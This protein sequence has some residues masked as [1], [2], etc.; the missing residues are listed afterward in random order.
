M[1][2][3]HFSK[4]TYGFSETEFAKAKS[5]SLTQFVDE[6]LSPNSGDDTICNEKLAA[7]Q[8]NIEYEHKVGNRTKKVKEDRP[9][10]YLS[11]SMTELWRLND[12]KVH[13]EEKQRP[14]H[15]VRMASWIRAVYSRWQVHELMVEFWHNHFNVSTD[16][17][18]RIAITFPVYDRD[19]IRK[20]TFGNF[21]TLLEAVSQS[22]AMLI[23]LDNYVSKASPAN[24]NYARELFELHTLGADHYL[25]HLYNRWREVPG[26]IEG[27]PVGYIDEDVYEAARAFTGWTIADGSDDERGGNFPNTGNFHYYEGWHDNYQK[28]ILGYEL[29]PNQAPLND[30]RKVL[31]LVAFHPGTAKHICSKLCRRFI[32]DDPPASI[33]DKAVRTWTEHQKSPDQ[34]RRTLRTIFLSEEFNNASNQKL[35]RPF[36]L[37]VSVLRASATDFNPNTNLNWILAR[38]GYKHFTWPTPTGHPDVESYWANSNMMLGRWNMVPTLLLEDWHNLT[39]WDDAALSAT[40]KLSCVQLAEFWLTKMLP[41][42][43]ME[44]LRKRTVNLLAMGGEETDPPAGSKEE[45]IDRIKKTVC[46][47]AMSPQFQYR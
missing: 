6:Q 30:G 23:Y 34:I 22:S 45:V 40:M 1:N 14:A 19:V 42:S 17:N 32:S 21:R 29:P 47:I 24:E 39:Q 37:A 41:E 2:P 10:N 18:E 8:L 3:S 43:A 33:I 46:L 15:E 25:N 4:L 11:A 13:Y 20:N 36:E 35:K 26:A 7:A 44:P 12:D 9:L 5:Q 31:D 28:R 16:A 38:L 27:K